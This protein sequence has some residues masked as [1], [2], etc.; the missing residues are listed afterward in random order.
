MGSLQSGMVSLP[1]VHSSPPAHQLLPGTPEVATHHDLQSPGGILS[2]RVKGTLFAIF[3]VLAL[4]PDSLLLRKVNGV[5]DFTVTFYRYAIFGVASLVGISVTSRGD[6]VGKFKGLG[7]WGVLA[8]L[9]LGITNLFITLAFQQTAAANVLVIQA[10]NPIISALLSRLLLGE[11]LP[12][13]TMICAVVSMGAIV[14]IFAGD[15]GS[16]GSNGLFFA[17]VSATSFG[18]YFVILR[19]VTVYLK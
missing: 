4:T 1:P 3:G 18:T 19:Y 16:G 12:L 8:G 7:R 11:V 10:S 5:P 13:R 9:T 15:S 14:L 2:D 17:M 6:I